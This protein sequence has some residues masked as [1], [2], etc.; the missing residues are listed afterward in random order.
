MEIITI[1]DND[2]DLDNAPRPVT[3]RSRDFD[4]PHIVA[5]HSHTRAQFLYASEGVMEVHTPAGIWVVV[6]N[7]AV[8]LP[9]NE[10]HEVRSRGNL[11]MRN[12]YFDPKRLSGLPP[13]CSV[14]T[15]SP[16]LRELALQVFS[17]DPLY[18]EEGADG[19]L[20]GVL[21]DQIRA[22]PSQPLHLPLP[23]DKR[24][25]RIT[26][27]IGID[28]ADKR[29]LKD[30]AD[31]ANASERTLARLF[32]DDVG[33]TFGQWRQQARLLAALKLLADGQ[34]V[35]GVA[36]DLGYDSQS[37]FIT[38]FRKTLGTTPRRYFGSDDTGT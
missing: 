20:M 17:L 32:K 37:A 26:E 1:P 11:R 5:R 16:L 30:W 6:P 12:L 22:V 34:P 9:P 4:T 2:D 38:M 28:P 14:V 23:R 27:T 21:L 18:D 8:W 25:Q 10:P 33:M 7:R 35:G 3:W 24:L 36:L 15:V 13:V 19:R 29:T 31:V